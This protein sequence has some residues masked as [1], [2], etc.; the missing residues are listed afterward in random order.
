MKIL[1]VAK[2][3]RG[4]GACVGGITEEGHSV[5]LV[6]HDAATNE[7]AGLEYEVGEV[8]EIE[9]APD[10]HIIPPHVENI[11]VLH[12]RRVKRSENLEQVI[13][14]YMPPVTGGPE[15][16]FDGLAQATDSGGLYIAE[17]TGLPHRST[18]FWKPDQPLRLDY[19]GKRIR[20]RYPTPSGGRT[21]TFVGF[22]EPLEVIPAGT[23]LRVSLAHWWRSKDK[24][25][26]EL[27]CFVQ[28]S[29]WFL[30]P[31]ESPRNLLLQVQQKVAAAQPDQFQQAR[32]VLKQTFGFSDFLP[33]QA[34]V[35]ARVLRHDDTLVV[36]PTGGGKSLCYQL[37]ALLH[38]GLTV[39]VSP[40]I[41]LMQDQVSQLR[42]LEVPAAFLNCT[43]PLH[44]YTAITSRIRHGATRILYVAPET[45]LRPEILLLLQQSR[46]ACIAID[47]AH[48]ISEWGHDFRP[49]YRQLQ[50]VRRRFPQAVCLALTATATPRVREDIRRLL[51]IPAEGEFVASFNRR[52]LF[53]GVQPRKDGLAQL[54]AFLEKHR[55]QSGIVYC[56]TRKQTEEV[57]ASLNANGWL[58]LPYHAA[59][60][61]DVRRRN[62]ERFS[63]D[64]V[65]LMVATVAFGMGINKSNVRFVVH[66]HLPKDVESYYQE[67]G[68]A[69]RD[70]L[71]A[72]CLLLY[73]RADAVVHRHF[74]DEGAASERP[75]RQA[76]LEALL[77]YAE[78]RDCRR[79]PLLAYFAETLDQP[80]GHCDNC[81]QPPDLGEK[82]DVTTE[83]QKFLSCVKRTGEMFGPNH[84]IAVLRGSR[85]ERVLSRGHDRLTTC[86]IGKDHST[87]AWREL[88]REFIHQDLVEQDLQFGGLRI[89]DKGWKVIKGEKV[90]VAVGQALAAASPTVSAKHDAELFERLRELRK[91]LAAQASVP[92]YVIFS[93]RALTEMAT[94]FPQDETQF[95]AINGVG[96]VKLANYGAAFLQVIREHCQARGLTPRPPPGRAAPALIVRP[97]VRRRFHEI[98]ELFMAGQTV[99]A[100]A[101]RY[102]SKRETVIQNLA[103]FHEAGGQLDPQ[104]VLALSRLSEADRLRVL[105]AFDR[106][107]LDRLAPV[108]ECL[109]GAIGYDE[110]HLLR[111]YRRCC[112]RKPND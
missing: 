23:L 112:E 66:Y 100:I 27:R 86:G 68:R 45:L 9:S 37:P 61:A 106:L 82:K 31:Q 49:E 41:A 58:A 43:M 47:E 54:L 75:G 76:R 11:I 17:R 109:S 4:G 60:D 81:V 6:A 10:E 111:L 21:L 103:Q 56:G 55:G 64:E 57:A 28:L 108:H 92:A 38:D 14:R 34:D 79:I 40:L 44:E 94:F 20:Y 78:A 35:I 18:M 98:G 77:R 67:I 73:S 15:K 110:L 59:L 36:M 5:R 16:L 50:E 101:E 39:V 104:R 65:P 3:R 69:G 48:C 2:T 19:E 30:E 52:N 71:P 1:I 96:E 93:D 25:D 84:I 29:G 33:V 89:T 22:Q 91:E 74:I 88:A 102:D 53:L 97:G 13:H 42:E 83:A 26:E 63:H 90:L 51:N 72:D 107:G 24:P 62:Q 105:A 7:R 99:E 8:W 80:C 70:G 46:L 85:A 32:Q 12:A 87:E 95:L